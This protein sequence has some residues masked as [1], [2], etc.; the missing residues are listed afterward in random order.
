MLVERMLED[1]AST[2]GALPLLQFAAAQMWESRDLARRMLTAGSYAAMGGIAGTL[3]THAEAVLAGVSPAQQHLVE[4]MF[5][6][7]VTAH[8]TRAIVDV[9]ELTALSPYEVPGL[10]STL[11]TAR[12]LVS[13]T[14]PR[15]NTSTV[16]I[17]HE[18]LITAWP[19]LRMWMDSGR[20]DAAF[21]VQLRSAAE[22]WEMRGRP[23]DLVWRGEMAEELR[24]Y[25]HRLGDTFAPREQQFATAVRALASRAS[26]RKR[27]AAMGAIVGLSA[28]VIAAVVV[29]FVIRAAEERAIDKAAEA[30]AATAKLADELKVVMQKDQEKALAEAKAVASQQEAV[31]AARKADVADA[32]V[33]Q[34]Q[35]E[36]QKT[37]AKLERAL[38]DAQAAFAKEQTLRQQVEKLLE[39]EK[40]RV[41]ALQDRSK[42]IATELK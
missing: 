40:K 23:E 7:L 10:V 17:V 33:Q 31:V 20:D 8:G 36:L 22:Q 34:S 41:K 35:A 18:S 2:P 37:N 39:N 6:R 25:A 12:L 29:V 38:A 42:K 14:D 21:M 30:E 16:E 32:Q 11:V 15:R 5:R 9:D 26:R 28:L 19:R 27:A 3:A 1:I 24:Y 4:A 13:G